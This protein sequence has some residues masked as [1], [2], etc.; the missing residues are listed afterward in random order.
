MSTTRIRKPEKPLST[1]WDA[2]HLLIF[3]DYRELIERMEFASYAQRI[4]DRDP[5][6][7]AMA[8]QRIEQLKSRRTWQA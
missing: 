2:M 5:F 7:K 1:F 4:E 8:Q 3:G 6:G